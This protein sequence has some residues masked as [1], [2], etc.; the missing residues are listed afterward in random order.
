MILDSIH[1]FV[2]YLKSFGNMQS[3]EATALPIKFKLWE[4][5]KKQ[6]QQQPTANPN[7]DYL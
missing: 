7:L 4:K 6:Q 3:C 5:K 1:K 2:L